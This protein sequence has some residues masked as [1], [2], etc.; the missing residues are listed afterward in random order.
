[1]ARARRP[2]KNKPKSTNGCL[3]ITTL[4]LIL[5]ALS[6]AATFYFLFLRPGPTTPPPSRSGSA[7]KAPSPPKQLTKAT[8]TATPAPARPSPTPPPADE[9]LPDQ[10]PESTVATTSEPHPAAR[11]G[12]RLAIIIDD[13]GNTRAIAEQLIALDLPLAF[14]ILPHSP[15]A[16]HLASLAKARG[17]DILLHLPMEANDPKWTPS[18]GTL[19]L[20]M[21]REEL[22]ATINHDLNTP[23]RPIGINN[24][25]GSRFSEDPVAM[26]LFLTTIKGRGLFF[27]DS[28]TSLNSVG[29][30]LARDMGVKTAKRDV[31]LDNEQDQTKILAQIGKALALAQRHGSAIAIGHPYPA[32]LKAL[33]IAHSRLTQEATLVPVHELVE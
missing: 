14:S 10:G 28:L 32:T 23:Y 9:P 4:L 20:S 15:H 25:M 21:S 3:I 13:I 8:Q 19:L 18:P 22:V 29:L 11:V 27:I 5:V 7:A 33:R 16:N 26:R 6:L 17:H 12:P 24:H 30:I 1:M 31:F 2:A